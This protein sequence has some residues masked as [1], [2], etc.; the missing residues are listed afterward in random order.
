MQSCR[1]LYLVSLQNLVNP[2]QRA[3]GCMQLWRDMR[4][5]PRHFWFQDVSITLAMLAMT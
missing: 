5:G 2:D 3:L 4:F 1:M